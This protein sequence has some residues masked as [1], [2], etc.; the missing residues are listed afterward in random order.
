MMKIS[1]LIISI[2]ICVILVQNSFALTLSPSE[3]KIKNVKFNKNYQFILLISSDEEGLRNFE[4]K[5]SKDYVK[6][7]PNKFML[8]EGEKKSVRLSVIFPNGMKDTEGKISV[9]PYMNNNPTPERLIIH[10]STQGDAEIEETI[11]SEDDMSQ[12]INFM[13]FIQ[14]KNIL[15]GVIYGLIILVSA[16]I[17]LFVLPDIKRTTIKINKS[18]NE[19]LK[20]HSEDKEKYKK[21]KVPNR[22][23]KKINKLE[24]KLDNADKSVQKITERIE[25]FI[26]KSDSW[27]K[28]NSEGKY[29]LE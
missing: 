22:D 27:L 14:N 21:I 23:A 11:S 1:R 5:P 29:G 10:Y 6:I 4:L 2:L 8:S 25:R 12:G 28:E 7:N 9:Q 19:K 24:K 15:L 13:S 26:E 17:V 16:M 20:K 3:L 18:F